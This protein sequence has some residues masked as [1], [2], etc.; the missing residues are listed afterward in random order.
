MIYL[1]FGER[2]HMTMTF[3][4][5]A[6]LL[7]SVV[8][9]P[10]CHSR[11]P[12]DLIIHHGLVYT[13]DSAFST[14]EAFAVKDGKILAVGKDKDIL[15]AYSSGQVVDAGGKPVYPGFIDAH[16]HF[17]GY[18]MSLFDVDL[19]GCASFEEVLD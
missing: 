18:G 3:R 19:F 1:T 8:L 7:L 17:V 2:K 14:A 6:A 15:D 13:V 5:I 4:S 16:A 11:Q 9:L 12:A 10:A